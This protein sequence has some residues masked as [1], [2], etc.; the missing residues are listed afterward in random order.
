[1]LTHE[2]KKLVVGY[3]YACFDIVHMGHIKHL[4][5][6]KKRCDK[7]VVGVLTNK[8]IME[9]KPQPSIGFEERKFIG[10]HIKEIDLV[11]EQDEYSPLKNAKKLKPDILFESTSHKPE[12]IANAEKVM[13]EIGGKVIVLPYHPE[14]S[15]TNIKE[16]IKRNGK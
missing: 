3:A 11:M 7:L 8:A 15:S 6:C 12:D 14:Q 16:T 13:A 5:E 1:M 9:R 4:I 10:E 2:E